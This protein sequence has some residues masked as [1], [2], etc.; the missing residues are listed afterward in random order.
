MKTIPLGLDS[1]D[2]EL[3]DYVSEALHDVVAD[4]V[5]RK[6]RTDGGYIL[7]T[8]WRGSVHEVIYQTPMRFFW[9]RLKRNRALFEFY[10]NGQNW[11]QD[12]YIDFGKSHKRTDGQVRAL[13][14]KI[15]DFMTFVTVEFDAHR[16]DKYWDGKV[17]NIS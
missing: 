3:N 4:A 2:P 1:A 17:D 7:A 5:V 13:Y 6:F 10:G 14:S 8:I 9:S 16:W 11:A 12:C 15:M